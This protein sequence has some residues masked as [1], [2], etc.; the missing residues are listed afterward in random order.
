MSTNDRTG[1]PSAAE[2]MRIHRKRQRNGLQCVRLLLHETEIDGL[3]RRGL[4]K[5]AAA[6]IHLLWRPRLLYSSAASWALGSDAK[7]AVVNNSS[8]Q[9]HQLFVYGCRLGLAN[10]SFCWCGLS[11]RGRPNR[12]PRSFARFRPSPVRARIN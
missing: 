12:T 6:A 11:F 3:V 4:L 7:R 10:V 2:R 8:I 5:R 1:S 9:N